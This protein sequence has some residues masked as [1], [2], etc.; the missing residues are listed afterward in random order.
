MG[1]EALMEIADDGTAIASGVLGGI[2]QA[3]DG[4]F[5]VSQG[6]DV[7]SAD[8]VRL[9]VLKAVRRAD[10]L[11]DRPWQRDVYVHFEAIQGVRAGAIALTI[12]ADRVD[13][14]GWL[15]PPLLP[16]LPA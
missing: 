10:I 11:V 9:G 12:P 5:Q 15:Q 3:E 6:M 1:P 7:V 8:G 14:M 4:S 13:Q 16:E 2:I